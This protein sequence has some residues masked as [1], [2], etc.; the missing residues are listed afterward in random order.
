MPM[1]RG[2]QLRGVEGWKKT[3][4]GMST[5]V[6]IFGSES[7]GEVEGGM[8]MEVGVEV[9]VGVGVGVG[10]IVG[11]RPSIDVHIECI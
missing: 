6:S 3:R 5:Y 10:S 2:R 9:G 8:E 7:E 4:T 11:D 1:S